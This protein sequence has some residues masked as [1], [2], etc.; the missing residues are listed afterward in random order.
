MVNISAVMATLVHG[1]TDWQV[2][3]N[4]NGGMCEKFDEL[5]HSNPLIDS[6]FFVMRAVQ[7]NARS[8]CEASMFT[9]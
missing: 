4:R 1:S 5:Y 2:F 9:S 3:V 7:F 6:I 8:A